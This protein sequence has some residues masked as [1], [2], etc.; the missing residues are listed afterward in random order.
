VSDGTSSASLAAFSVTVTPAATSPTSQPFPRL[1][2][3][4]IGGQPGSAY[5][6]AWANYLAAMNVNIIGCYAGCGASMYGGS[7][8]AFVA[9]VLALSP[10]TVNSQVFQYYDTDAGNPAGT[11][12]YF[13][14][15]QYGLWNLVAANS[16]WWAWTNGDTQASHVYN[17]Y[18]SP[19]WYQ[20]NQT[21]AAGKNGDGLYW[22]EAAAQNQYQF[23]WTSTGGTDAADNMAG[24]YHDVFDTGPRVSYD[25]NLSGIFAATTDPAFGQS[26]R[27]GMATGPAW[28]HANT[29]KLI[30]GN[31]APWG[32]PG[33]A[34]TT[35]Y[36]GILNGGVFE[37]AFGENWSTMTWG[38]Y[39]DFRSQYSTIMSN[40]AAPAYVI[41]GHD[42][43]SSTGTDPYQS[44]PYAAM[45]FGLTATLV[46]GD[47]YYFGNSSYNVG[48]SEWFD[49]YA[50]N[51]AGVCSTHDGTVNSVA[52]G[53]GYMGY[54]TSA[55]GSIS[56][57]GGPAYINGLWARLFYNP[58]T[59][60]T[61]VA[62]NSPPGSGSITINASFFG[63]TKFKMLTG[64]QDPNI[65]NGATVSSITIPAGYDGRI[66]QLL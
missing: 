53:R 58:T 44:K 2:S 31:V 13:T 16:K 25:Y 17:T 26:F 8:Q 32:A 6:D 63:R 38:G 64:S 5:D 35:G 51:S 43:L 39:A 20:T 50:A 14:G 47:G 42:N 15:L 37:G 9:Q 4:F 22:E 60:L 36:A 30:I 28:I 49:E 10:S 12:P 54:P 11:R 1:G 52:G 56:G 48:E 41:L 23:Y 40:M 3:Y 61:W 27:D 24:L 19:T 57:S 65:N 46:N 34:P 66:A 7:R 33:Q 59:G 29:S 55:W 45:R 21:L 62:I 18:F